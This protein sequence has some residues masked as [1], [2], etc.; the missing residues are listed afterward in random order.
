MADTAE[1]IG[2]VMLKA[3]TLFSLH[4]VAVLMLWWIP[5]VRALLVALW[6]EYLGEA[7]DA[8]VVVT[9]SDVAKMQLEKRRYL[10]HVH[11]FT[12]LQNVEI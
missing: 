12:P 9:R 8:S 1:I 3:L 4:A 2:K 5:T 10:R 6:S 11:V 7:T